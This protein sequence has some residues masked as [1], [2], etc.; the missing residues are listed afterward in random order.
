MKKTIVLSESDLH[1]IIRE[2]VNIILNESEETLWAV[3]TAD[4]FGSLEFDAPRVLLLIK[5][6]TKEEAE[7]KAENR[8]IGSNWMTDPVAEAHPATQEEIEKWK[9][10][11]FFE[12]ERR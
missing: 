10:K 8:F 2:S 7:R 1:K 3:W 5:A 6:R 9:R 11:K 4:S 12:Y